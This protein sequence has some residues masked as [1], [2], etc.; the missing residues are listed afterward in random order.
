MEHTPL[1]IWIITD[2]KPGHRNQLVALADRLSDRT[3]TS[4]FEFTARSI[5][6]GVLSRRSAPD[7][8]LILCA[9]SRTHLAA[10]AAH[11]TLGGRLVVCMNPSLPIWLFDLCLIPRHGRAPERR[12]IVR[13]VGAIVNTRPSREHDPARGVILIGGPSKH[14]DIDADALVA[15]IRRI[16]GASAGVTWELTTSRRTPGAL[17][18]T[19]DTLDTSNLTV[20]PADRTPPGWVGDRLAR[21]GVAW[22][23][24]DSVSM[25]CEAVT[26]GC[27]VGLLPMPRN[28]GA[29]RSSRVAHF[30]KDYIDS[31]LVTTYEQWIAGAPLTP[32]TETIDEADRCAAIIL[33]RFFPDR[34]RHQAA[35]P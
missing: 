10:V 15:A 6:A 33:D 28:A 14:H 4:I 24:E 35:H 5:A 9:G 12:N 22:I 13:T 32:P 3:G 16:V 8:D 7:P 34:A 27:S 29:D 20:T 18:E 11:A 25:M 21:A 31:R 19:L 17:L 23:T 30:I 1:V 26:S 2:G